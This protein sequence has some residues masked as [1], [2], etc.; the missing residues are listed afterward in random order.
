MASAATTGKWERALSAMAGYADEQMREAKSAR[1]LEG[2]YRFSD[3]LVQAA[4]TASLDVHFA[5]EFAG[6][7]A[8]KTAKR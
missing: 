7:K 1:F 6:S 8:R 4:R 2:I 5:N 3:F